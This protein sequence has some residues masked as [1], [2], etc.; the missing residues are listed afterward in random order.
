M[1]SRNVY[2]VN[3]GLGAALLAL[4]GCG[5]MVKKDLD[6]SVI[7]QRAVQRWDYLIAHQAEKAY[8]Y[9]SPGYRA[10]KPRATYAEEMNSR[11]IHWSHVQFGSQTCDADTCHV[12]LV[13]DYTLK[14]SGPIGAVTS[15]AF[16]VETWL[17]VD[18]QWYYLPEPLRSPHLKSGQK[19]L[20]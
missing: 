2:F 11:G 17:K 16:V 10:T 15:K 4:A 1:K 19:K 12:H 6:T 18:G 3:I 14:Q 8:D 13:V 9:L 20:S 7:K 5:A